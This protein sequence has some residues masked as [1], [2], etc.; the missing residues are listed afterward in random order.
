MKRFRRGLEFKAHRIV[1]HSTLG[2]RVIK[3]KR[4]KTSRNPGC[5][6]RA[7]SSRAS[8][9][10]PARRFQLS[11]V[12]LPA[13]S[14]A[15]DIQVNCPCLLSQLPQ[16]VSACGQMPALGEGPSEQFGSLLPRIRQKVRGVGVQGHHCV[17]EPPLGTRPE[18]TCSRIRQLA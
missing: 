12:P 16:T 1:Y 9:T 17:G 3:K 13:K 2:S 10:L 7:E 15:P 8:T 5:C 18:R 4:K 14:S 11:Q 6:Y